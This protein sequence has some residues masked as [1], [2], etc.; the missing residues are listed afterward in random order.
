MRLLVI[1]ETDNWRQLSDTILRWCGRTGYELRVFAPRNKRRKFLEE[2]WDANYNYYL[3]L[4]DEIIVTKQGPDEYARANGFELI[5]EIP[6]G[7]KEWRKRSAFRDKEIK[8]AY[9][10]IAK[11]RVPFEKNPRVTR[12]TFSNGAILRR[13]A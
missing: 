2:V 6:A 4:P 5:L 8:W 10:A 13:V 12:K 1:H 3:A 7:L 9:E 11:A